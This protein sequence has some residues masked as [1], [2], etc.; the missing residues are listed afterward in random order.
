MEMITY[1]NRAGEQMDSMASKE[2]SFNL[3]LTRNFQIGKQQ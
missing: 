1:K 3:R 2:Q